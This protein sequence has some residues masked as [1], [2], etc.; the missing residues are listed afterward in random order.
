MTLSDEGLLVATTARNEGTRPLPYGEGHHPYL[1]VTGNHINASTLHVPAARALGFGERTLPTAPFDVA[2][3]PYDFC[4]PRAI[5]STVLAHTYFAFARDADDHA[6]IRLNE[7][8]LWMDEHYPFA[9]VL[10]GEDLAN[11][12]EHRRSLAV[13]PM[14][15]PPNA[16]HTG[17]HDITLHP[18]ES[19]THRWGIHPPA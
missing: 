2:G 4:H 3:T 15:C 12:A 5:G 11:P 16:F 19:L 7:T 9:L 18:G 13:E 6:R 14:T 8:T 1:A 10:S 17:Q